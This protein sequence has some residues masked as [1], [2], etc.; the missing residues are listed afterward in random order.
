MKCVV[1]ARNGDLKHTYPY[2]FTGSFTLF[3]GAPR[4]LFKV[5]AEPSDFRCQERYGSRSDDL[6]RHLLRV[7]IRSFRSLKKTAQKRSSAD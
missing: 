5:N 3:R 2:P 6:E 7:D 4:S 1:V